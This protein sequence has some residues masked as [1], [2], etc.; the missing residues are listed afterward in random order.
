MECAKA[1]VRLRIP[2]NCSQ[3]PSDF[4]SVVEMETGSCPLCGWDAL[5][6]KRQSKGWG[7]AGRQEHRRCPGQWLDGGSGGVQ[8]LGGGPSRQV[9]SL[10]FITV[11]EAPSPHQRWRLDLVGGVRGGSQSTK[12]WPRLL[13]SEE[14]P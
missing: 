4:H 5:K 7:P 13:E 9:P 12:L 3:G 6:W 1:K 11:L 2:E 10:A 14:F 8:R